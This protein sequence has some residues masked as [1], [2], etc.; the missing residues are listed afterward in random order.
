MRDE[1]LYLYV[2]RER[3]VASGVTCD[4]DPAGPVLSFFDTVHF[5]MASVSPRLITACFNGI[6]G[7]RSCCLAVVVVCAFSARRLVISQY[8]STRL[9]FICKCSFSALWHIQR[10][11]T[12]IDWD[13][14]TSYSTRSIGMCCGVER[15]VALMNLV[16][17]QPKCSIF[18]VGCAPVRFSMFL[19]LKWK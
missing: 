16:C 7:P 1:T 8:S 5:E 17:V 19:H 3:P 13:R 12:Q 11:G 14:P 9:I 15:R 6:R 10:A 4:N 2:P 18:E